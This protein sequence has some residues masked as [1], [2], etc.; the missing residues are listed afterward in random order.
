VADTSYVVDTD[1]SCRFHDR[2]QPWAHY[3]PIQLDLSDL[4]D[5]LMFF[6]G[7][8]SGIGAHEELAAKIALAGREWSKAYWRREDLVS[9][10]FRCE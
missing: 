3:V 8:G 1:T 9:Y 2:V 6:R 10:F 4:H 5:V 7:D